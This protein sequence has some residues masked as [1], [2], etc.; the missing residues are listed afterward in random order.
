MEREMPDRLQ[1]W[2]TPAFGTGYYSPVLMYLLLKHLTFLSPESTCLDPSGS[3]TKGL[4]TRGTPA[5]P[6]Y[7]VSI[8]VKQLHFKGF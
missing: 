5:V 8:S 3:Y 7:V 6:S 2:D 4:K 1:F